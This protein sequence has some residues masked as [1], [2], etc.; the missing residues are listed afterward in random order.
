AGGLCLPLTLPHATWAG[1]AERADSRVRIGSDAADAA[2][3]E[4]DLDS[5]RHAPGWAA[6]VAGVIWTLGHPRGVDVM[7]HSTVPI[8]S[9]LS[10]AAA[11]ECSAAL[12]LS[13]LAG[14]ELTEAHRRELVTACVRAET[15]VAG[16]PTGELDQSAA[17][18]APRDGALLIDFGTDRTE[19]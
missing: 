16:V 3:W 7:V 5:V 9:G 15:E 10:S 17:Q 14:R 13:H 4:G 19:E 2:D 11:L 12:A 18:L 6:Y 1:V 8:G